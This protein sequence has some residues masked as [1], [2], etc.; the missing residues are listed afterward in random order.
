MGRL[1]AAR[2]KVHKNVRAPKQ[3]RGVVAPQ[4]GMGRQS[5]PVRV[6]VEG[7]EVLW[8]GKTLTAAP[9]LTKKLLPEASSC[10]HVKLPMAFCWPAAAA[11]RFP[12]TCSPA[13]TC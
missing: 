2:M 3:S 5:V 8:C 4:E 6:D 10:K 12:N 7:G 13:S 11:G 9:V 1:T